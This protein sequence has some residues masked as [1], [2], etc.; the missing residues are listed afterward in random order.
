M[1]GLEWLQPTTVFII[2]VCAG[3]LLSDLVPPGQPVRE[4]V[5]VV[6][7]LGD[8]SSHIPRHLTQSPAEGD[9]ATHTVFSGSES[10]CGL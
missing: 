7:A 6:P 5:Q 8:G 3:N 1:H 10:C 2:P 9:P 4:S